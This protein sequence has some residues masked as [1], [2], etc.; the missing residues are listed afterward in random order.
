VK[1]IEKYEKQKEDK[2]GILFH[3]KINRDYKPPRGNY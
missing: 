1:L 2:M 3:P